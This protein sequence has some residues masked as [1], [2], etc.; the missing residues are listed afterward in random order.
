MSLLAKAL[1]QQK[2]EENL[3]SNKKIKLEQ[4]FNQVEVDEMEN[5]VVQKNN[6][7]GN[8][9]SSDSPSGSA[10]SNSNVSVLSGSNENEKMVVDEL[11]INKNENCVTEKINGIE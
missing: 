1:G 4:K 10:N 8:Q 5:Q 11:A 3:I 6:N 9:K 2:N 7:G